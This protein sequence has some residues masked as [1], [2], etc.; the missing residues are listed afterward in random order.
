MAKHRERWVDWCKQHDVSW[1]FIV[2]LHLAARE[3]RGLLY[4]LQER[5]TLT[6][7]VQ[8]I[9][10][11]TDW[12]GQNYKHATRDQLIGAKLFVKDGSFILKHI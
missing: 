1:G 4:I 3:G 9:L 12:L 7:K 11:V 6:S 8:E 10:K 2:S 5:N